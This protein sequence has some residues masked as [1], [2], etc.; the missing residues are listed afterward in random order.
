KPGQKYIQLPYNKIPLGSKYPT[1]SFNY[2]KGI[3]DILGSDVNFDKWRFSIR[4]D[5]NLKLAGTLNYKI[6]VGGFIN[7]NRVPVQDYQHFNGNQSKL[8]A[9]AYMSSFQL[10]KYYKHSNIN[11]FFIWGNV[12]HHLN[13]LLTNKIPLFKRLNWN[14]VTGAN[15]FYVNNNNNYSEVFVGL[16]N[17]F[18]L[19]R[20]DFVAGFENGKK[21]ITGIKIGGG[22]LLGNSL[23]GS[24]KGGNSV[25][26]SL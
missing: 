2:T 9:G 6:N 19:F 17:I 18:K 1:L 13:G 4:D 22:G 7:T 12:E 16:E 23:G 3:S 24:R 21:V 20:L 5:K 8:A 11:D 15:A 10:L 25:S 14:L 26:I